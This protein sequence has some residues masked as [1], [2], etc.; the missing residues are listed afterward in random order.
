MRS[1]LLH[2]IGRLSRDTHGVAA[3]EFALILPLLLLLYIGS[4]EATLLYTTD[5]GVA[6]IASTVADLVARSKTTVNKSN[7]DDYFLAAT[8]VL[9]PGATEDLTQVVSLI[10]IDADGVATV[11]WSAASAD[12]AEREPDDEFPLDADSEISQM[13]RNASGFLV[14]GEASYPYVPMTGLGIPA[15]VNLR[16]VEYFLPRREREIVYDPNA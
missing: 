5:R 15:T 1:W 9:K 4:V 10:S 16:H 13:A 6:T 12:G 8:N 14:V 7:L 2:R 11:V 3:V